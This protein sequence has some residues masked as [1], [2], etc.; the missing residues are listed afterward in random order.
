LLSRI[1]EVFNDDD[2][3]F[4]CPLIERLLTSP[5][6]LFNNP[7][8]KD[9]DL[10]ARIIANPAVELNCVNE[11]ITQLVSKSPTITSIAKEIGDAVFEATSTISDSPTRKRSLPSQVRKSSRP[12]KHSPDTV[13]LGPV[14][15]E[16]LLGGQDDAPF[17]G[18]P[19][20]MIRELLN[21]RRGH[22]VGDEMLSRVLKG[23][24]PTTGGVL[25]DDGK[26]SDHFMPLRWDNNY[27]RLLMKHL[28]PEVL[29]TPLGFS[30]LLVWMATGQG[31]LTTEFVENNVMSFS[32]LDEAVATFQRAHDQNALGETIIFDNMKVWGQSA[33]ALSFKAKRG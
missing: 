3:I 9:A 10:S 33:K 25:L 24:T 15:L 17:F 13:P 14:C 12:S 8:R 26:D 1:V 6:L 7:I 22:D 28:P 11:Y 16:T 4:A 18:Q 23:L 27:A 19:A 2:G 21:F 32:S 5:S 31:N 30:S 29:V 20:L